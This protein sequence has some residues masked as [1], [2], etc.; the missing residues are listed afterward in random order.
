MR[1]TGITFLDG[2]A[3]KLAFSDGY[4]AEMDLAPALAPGD[5]LRDMSVFLQGKPNGLTIEW[6]GGI[7][8]CPDA[9]RAWC[10]AGKVL[11]PEETTNSFERSF[12]G[13][14]AA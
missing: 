14:L 4:S 8:F 1:V 3:V 7:D 6:P 11:S 2:F 12:P 13:C 10:E 9:L 5:P